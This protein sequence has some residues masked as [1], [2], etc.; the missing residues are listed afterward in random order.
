METKNKTI[1]RAINAEQIV[2]RSDSE[3]GKRYIEFYPIVFNQKSKLI[4]EWGEV[5]YEVIE[6]TAPDNVLRDPGLNVIATIDHKREKML[7]R[8]K[9]GTLEL[10]KDDKGVKAI[11][12]VPNTTL[13]N[14]T[15]ELVS[16]GD[17]YESSFIFSIAE[18]GMRY[19]RS[20]DIPTRYISDFSALRDVAIVID[21]AYANTN[22][23]L[24]AQEWE[25]ETLN[26]EHDTLNSRSAAALHDILRKEIEIIQL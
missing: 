4:R 19:D 17:Y 6:P 8:N 2:V 3:S 10:V 12:E 7:G 14:D 16:R 24:R 11:V 9:S 5:F 15:A 23:K 18:K 13:G 21:G 25:N 22:V 26:V 20:E 1:S